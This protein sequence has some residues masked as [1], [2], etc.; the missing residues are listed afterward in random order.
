MS[1]I[2]TL[3]QSLAV[4]LT[5]RPGTAGWAG[6]PGHSGVCSDLGI[7]SPLGL[8]RTY[9][10]EIP[11]VRMRTFR[12]LSNRSPRQLSY[13]PERVPLR[14]NRPGPPPAALSGK[15]AIRWSRKVVLKCACVFGL[16]VTI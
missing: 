9:P 11:G 7:F 10:G 1:R 5:I 3:D 8:A 6:L 13:L 2:G 4:A 15:C 12:V 14:F 16:I